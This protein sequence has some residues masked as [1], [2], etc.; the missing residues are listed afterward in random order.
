MSKFEYAVPFI[1]ITIFNHIL[2]VNYFLLDSIPCK[3]EIGTSLLDP[4][5]ALSALSLAAFVHLVTPYLTNSSLQLVKK[6]VG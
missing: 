2:P 3:A 4:L 6:T 1:I 5:R